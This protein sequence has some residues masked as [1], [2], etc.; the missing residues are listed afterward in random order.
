MCGIAGIFGEPDG[1]VVKALTLA[2]KHRGPDSTGFYSRGDLHLGITRLRIIDL[3]HGDQPIFNESRDKVI[4]FNGE[5]Y[6][7]RELR[8]TLAAVGHTFSTRSDTEVILHLYEEYGERCVEHL[9]GMFAFAIV[10]GEKLFLAR[11]RLGIKPLYYA[12]LPEENLFLFASECKA[13]L[14]CRKV[15]AELNRQALADRLVLTF[16]PGRQ[17]LFRGIERLLP[18]ETMTVAREQEGSLS[19]RRRQYYQL[20][21]CPEAEE[22]GFKECRAKLIDLFRSTVSSHMVS[23]VDVALTLSGGLDSSFLALMINEVMD[24]NLLAFTIG[25]DEAQDD[26]V[27]AKRLG[28]HLKAR[29]DVWVTSFSDFLEAVP[30]FVLA[31][32]R[33]S[34]LYAMAA[35]LLFRR[36]GEHVKVCMNGEGADELFGGYREYKRP[37]F[38]LESFRRRL[39][40]A[41]KLGLSLSGETAGIVRRLTRISQDQ[42]L[43]KVFEVNLTERLVFHHLDL[44]DHLGMAAG[45]EVRVPF[46]DHVLVEFVNRLPISYKVGR[47]QKVI[48][49]AAA[50]EAFGDAIAGVAARKKIGFP[51]AGSPH[52]R[53][54]DSLCE[55]LLPA[56]YRSGHELGAYFSSKAKLLVFEIF[57]HIFFERRGKLDTGFQVMDFIHSRSAATRMV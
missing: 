20:C 50:V 11:D 37:C 13:L 34:N 3:E 39:K 49:R 57:Q 8:A 23:D 54:F 45:L 2:L 7:H 4:V 40:T 55:E 56:G 6:N 9:R 17:T 46:M 16:I 35:F 15:P 48:L 43:Q 33:A 19:L 28:R 30:A 47:A 42:C 12:F 44:A 41:E 22:P 32:E 18:G 24:R 36:V 21:W 27:H 25:S 51:Q 31:E 53:Q 38:F 5:I 1:E 26:I 10:D 29:H 14:R 52:L